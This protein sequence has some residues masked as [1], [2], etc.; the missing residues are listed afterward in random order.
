ME[1]TAREEAERKAELARLEAEKK[2][3][4]ERER[5]VAAQAEQSAW[6]SAKASD[7][8]SGYRDYLDNYA[9]GRYAELAKAA[10]TGGRRARKAGSRA[11][12]R[13]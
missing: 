3:A 8:A 2:A 5:Q 1:R 6:E 10:A 7:S 9:K 12:A 4:A 11:T 13:G